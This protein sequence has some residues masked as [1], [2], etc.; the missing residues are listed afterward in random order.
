MTD[1]DP[2]RITDP[3]AITTASP[4]P[5]TPATY[6]PAVRWA[7]AEPVVRPSTPRKGGRGRWA[8]TIVVV[9]L[10]IAAT[11]AIAALL[12]GS[13]PTA[14]VLG[15]VPE[16]TIMYGEV[17]LDLPGDQRR[18]VGEFLSTFPGFADQAALDTKLD[19]VLD[20]L[21][22]DLSKGNQ[23]YTTDIKPWFG[24]ELAFSVGPLP[25]AAPMVDDPS[26]M[27]KVRFLVLLSIKDGPGAQA[28]FQAA[29]LKSGVTTT[30]ETYQ[31]VTLTLFDKTGDAPK[32]ALALI[33]GKVAAVGDVT[34]VKAAIDTKGQGGFANEP[35]PKT[36]LD[37]ADGDHI[38]FMY[39]AVSPWLD[40]MTDLSKATATEFGGPAT[41][42]LESMA[43][44]LPDWGAFWLRVEDDAVVMDATAPKPATTLGPT[45]DR[46]SKV[47]EHIPATAMVVAISHDYGATL[48]QVLALYKAEPSL[49][50]MIDQ[51]ETGLG[52]LGGQDAVLA[53][54]GDTAIVVN[55][56]VGSPE[57]GIVALP[58]DKAAA[59]RLFTSLRSFIALG[60]AQQ[61]IS[62]RDETY[63][64]TTITIVDV[65]DLA[66]LS[67][68]GS[69]GA[70]APFPM[71]SGHVEIAYAVTDDIVVVGSGPGFVK[72]VLDTTS[73]T[74]IA[75]NDRYKGLIDRAGTGT[76]SV[77]VDIAAIRVLLEKALADADPGT[78]PKYESDVKPYLSPFD[79][80]VASGSVGGDL[81]ESTVIITVK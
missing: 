53:W 14:T 29:L 59:E 19:E 6:E 32:G 25:P 41:I 71:P 16:Q 2:A 30:S 36:A 23:T 9:A 4:E 66:A 31:G 10:V 40:W 8:V 33:D 55:D 48:K 78:L 26:A 15:Y 65:G 39:I 38:G 80:L 13:S 61:G 68:M 63:A 81:T 58:T 62:V 24:G 3:D 43:S 44:Y 22:K 72:H 20:D 70:A 1:Q 73:G 75:S 51:L 54:I 45:D 35:D 18:A 21:I 52:V 69:A 60:G 27:D 79:A 76:G 34:S 12:T 42:G 77:F 37:S 50:E 49:K 74:S 56:S 5:M 17:R 67:G 47:A 28:W 7:P 11:A 46:T 64:G 57:G